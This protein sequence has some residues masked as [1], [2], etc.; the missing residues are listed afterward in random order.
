M[1][2][3]LWAAAVGLARRSGV[4]PVAR[5]LSVD[6]GALRRRVAEAARVRTE[7]A[8]AHRFVEFSGAQLLGVASATG[9]VVE[10][11]R[12]DDFT[13]GGPRS[14]IVGGRALRG[15]GLARV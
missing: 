14:V 8:G 3:E 15:G 6:Y 11:C 1:P 5:A 13:V 2:A 12:R 7:G 9:S 10:L 4:Y